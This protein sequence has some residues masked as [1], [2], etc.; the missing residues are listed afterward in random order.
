MFFQ[1]KRKKAGYLWQAYIHSV[2]VCAHVRV[3]AHTRYFLH[4]QNLLTLHSN[5]KYEHKT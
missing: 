3:H 1:L 5:A 2:C 4:Y